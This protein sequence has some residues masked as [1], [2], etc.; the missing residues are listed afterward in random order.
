ME[1]KLIKT[2]ST[3]IALRHYDSIRELLNKQPS[4]SQIKINE[5]ARGAKYLP[6]GVIEAKLDEAYSGLWQTRN[7]R[8]QV[9]VNEV[10]GSIE[11]HVFI[12]NVGWLVREGA[13]AVMIQVEKGKGITDPNNKIK[14]TLVK[15]YPHLKSEC[16]KNA[17]KSLGVTFGRNL[18][19]K[20]DAAYV[21]ALDPELDKPITDDQMQ[22]I[23]SFVHT[24]TIE[25]KHKEQ[26]LRDMSMYN[27][28]RAK[29]CIAYLEQNQ[30][31]TFNKEL[32]RKIG[33][34]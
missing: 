33:R 3:E 34:S 4:K 16:I 23:D 14:N 26:I 32:D 22:L 11:L 29:K 24:S 28:D 30:Q 5:Q 27:Q 7:F 2:E 31:D 15:D 1:N 12:P 19:R 6:I 10:V 8:T 17:A 18:N 20:A 13:A 25:E 21:P 9:I